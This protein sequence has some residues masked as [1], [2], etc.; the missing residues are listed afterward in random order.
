MMQMPYLFCGPYSV[1]HIRLVSTG[2]PLDRSHRKPCLVALLSRVDWTPTIRDE[3]YFRNV[4]TQAAA[5]IPRAKDGHMAGFVP[6]NLNDCR[7]FSRRDS[8]RKL[9]GN[10]YY[11]IGTD[12]ALKDNKGRTEPAQ[13]A[14]RNHEG[15][16]GNLVPI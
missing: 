14:L 6:A 8:M 16:P 7:D 10:N 15:N 13:I 4:K 2:D 3:I 1:I 9:A 5:T 12:L 11:K